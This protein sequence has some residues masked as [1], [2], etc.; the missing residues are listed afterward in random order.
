MKIII[1]FIFVGFISNQDITDL[2]CLGEKDTSKCSSHEISFKGF[3]CYKISYS[4]SFSM[5]GVFPDSSEGRKYYYQL[6]RGILKESLAGNHGVTKTSYSNNNDLTG[7]VEGEQ[8]SITSEKTTEKDVEI[9]SKNNTCFYQFEGRFYDYIDKNPNQI[10]TYLDITDKNICFNT[11]GF[12][13]LNGLIDCGYAE[14]TITAGDREATLKTCNFIANDDLPEELERYMKKI[15]ID[16][17]VNATLLSMING[18]ISGTP[19][20]SASNLRQLSTDYHYLI[21][22]ESENGKIVKYDSESEEVELVA[23]P[24]GKNKNKKTTKKFNEKKF[25]KIRLFMLLMILLII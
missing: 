5:C 22:V 23:N 19:K 16:T 3:S 4:G 17:H 14:I 10:G 1:L 13:D 25:I 11:D 15:L 2:E 6:H 12:D 18:F 20:N 24:N 8:I 9:A 21:T 7:E